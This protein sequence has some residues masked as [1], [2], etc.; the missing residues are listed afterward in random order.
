M[1]SM[2]RLI[3]EG[4]MLAKLENKLINEQQEVREM[5][6]D[7]EVGYAKTYLFLRKVW[8]G[9]EGGVDT[10]EDTIDRLNKIVANVKGG[11]QRTLK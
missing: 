2:D 7:M 11:L 9:A 3:R 6:E 5:Q 8:S 4:R 10:V 1:A